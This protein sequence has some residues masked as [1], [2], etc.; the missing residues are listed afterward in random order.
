MSDIKNVYV[1]K[2]GVEYDAEQVGKTRTLARR[3]ENLDSGSTVYYILCCGGRMY[4][5]Y[6]NDVFYDK[7]ANRWQFRKVPEIVYTLYCSFLRSKKQSTLR[8]AE[9]QI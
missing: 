9:R 1:S 4:N 5:P 7:G 6:N 2:D 3:S 8:Q